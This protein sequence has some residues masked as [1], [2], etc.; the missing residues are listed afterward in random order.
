MMDY[1]YKGSDLGLDFDYY[2][3]TQVFIKGLMSLGVY[4]ADARRVL[5]ELNK[6]NVLK[7]RK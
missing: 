7:I 5:Q 1:V 3:F 6:G 2:S 4:A